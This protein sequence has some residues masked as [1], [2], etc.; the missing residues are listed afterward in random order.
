MFR[1]SR[2][3][4]IVAT[5]AALGLAIASA[6]VWAETAQQDRM[7]SCNADPQA[8]TLHGADRKAFMKTCLSGAAAP[9][10]A[11]T[12]AA[13]AAPA[14]AEKA[15]PKAKQLNSQQLK[16]KSC[17]ADAKTKALKGDARKQFM[18]TC[19]KAS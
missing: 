5:V 10:A 9:A 7:K 6:S 4:S 3:S 2:H 8:K 12:P 13:S 18:S 19:L 11:A 14:A 16:M 1:S 15:A 17:S